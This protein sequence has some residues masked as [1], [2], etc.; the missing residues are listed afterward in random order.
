MK[1]KNS[2]SLA[3]LLLASVALIW[4]STFSLMKNT[5]DRISVASFLGWRFL[6]ASALMALLRP[7]SFR[8]IKKLFLIRAVIIGLLLSAGYLFQTYGLTQTTVA[9]TGFI[10]GLYSVFVPLIAAG[11]FKDRVSAQQWIAVAM[12]TLGLELLAFNGLHIGRGEFLVFLSAIL[13][14]FHI[15]ALSHWAPGEDVYT[16]TMIQMAVVGLVALCTTVKGGI[17]MPVDSGVWAAIIYTAICASA[18]AFMVQTWAQS[19]MSA[20]TVGVVL[21]LE[22]IFA[23]IFGV[24]FSHEHLELKTLVG[25]GFVMVGLYLII[26]FDTRSTSS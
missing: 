14:A 7:Q 13:F 23:A 9:K 2:H 3:F 17:H 5:L 25:G 10:T 16:L 26:F 8:Y 4:G 1:V 24:I 11:I 22:Y 18:I 21:T 6:L 19:F 15:V 20:T 12:A